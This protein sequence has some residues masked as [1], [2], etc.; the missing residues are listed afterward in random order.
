MRADIQVL[1]DFLASHDPEVPA[2]FGYMLSDAH[3]LGYDYPCGGAGMLLS[4]GAYDV[5]G[6]VRARAF[7][8]VS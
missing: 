6:A 4:A 2:M 7:T 5:P 3:V 1:L 8:R